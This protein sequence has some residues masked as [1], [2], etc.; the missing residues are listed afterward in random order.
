MEQPVWS[1]LKLNPISFSNLRKINFSNFCLIFFSH[2]ENQNPTIEV[3]LKYLSRFFSFL[4]IWLMSPT[5]K[6]LSYGYFYDKNVFWD[7]LIKIYLIPLFLPSHRLWFFRVWL[8]FVQQSFCTSL[9]YIVTFRPSVICCFSA[10]CCCP[11]IRSVST[12]S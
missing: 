6:N 2:S 3:L 11:S 5:C 4:L 7:V 12:F 9:S 10:C 8:T 1:F